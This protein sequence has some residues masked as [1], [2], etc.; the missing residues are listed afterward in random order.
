[1]ISVDSDGITEIEPSISFFHL[2]G[3]LDS[4]SKK[5]S[6]FEEELPIVPQADLI[7][8]ALDE[9]VGPTSWRSSDFGDIA[10]NRGVDD[11]IQ[12]DDDFDEMWQ[13]DLWETE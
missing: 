5:V 1:M 13:Q 11:D 2:A 4:S 6:A 9:I 8:A 12:V 10:V 3:L 7:D